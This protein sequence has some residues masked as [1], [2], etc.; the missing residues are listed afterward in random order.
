VVERH[1]LYIFT[2]VGSICVYTGWMIYH[3]WGVFSDACSNTGNLGAE[4]KLCTI[5]E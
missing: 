2:P 1:E 3:V 5:E 4:E